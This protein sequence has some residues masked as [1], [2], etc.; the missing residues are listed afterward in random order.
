M[1]DHIVRALQNPA[2]ANETSMMLRRLYGVPEPRVRAMARGLL[3]P[4]LDI[5]T[6]D[7]VLRYLKYSKDPEGTKAVAKLLDA[8]GQII[9][10]R[11]SSR[12]RGKSLPSAVD[13]AYHW[14]RYEC[15]LGNVG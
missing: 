14:T 4:A 1:V 6:L 2:S 5:T 9:K 7:A 13:T 11:L 10:S 8:S 12:R 15:Y 3:A